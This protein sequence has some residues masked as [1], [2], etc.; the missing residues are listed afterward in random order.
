MRP[1]AVVVLD[2]PMD[3]G[4]RTPVM[5]AVCRVRNTWKRRKPALRRTRRREATAR[6]PATHC[7][8]SGSP[9]GTR[10][11]AAVPLAVAG[12]SLASRLD[13]AEVAGQAIAL[14]AHFG[15]G[16]PEGRSLRLALVLPMNHHRYKSDDAGHND[17]PS[18]ATCAR[19]NRR[20]NTHEGNGQCQHAHV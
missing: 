8:D 20:N 1:V 14:A 10:R 6:I 5:R 12:R 11:S 4:V 16:H 18:G 9:S 19:R 7:Q 2:V 17:D 3:Y 15:D 13:V